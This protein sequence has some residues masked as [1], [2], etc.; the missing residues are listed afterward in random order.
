MFVFNISFSSHYIHKSY[1]TSRK[2]H[3]HIF[4]SSFMS[5]SNLRNSYLNFQ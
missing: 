1:L 5:A 3:F 4:S 2:G